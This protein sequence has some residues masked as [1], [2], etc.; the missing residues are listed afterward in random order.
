MYVHVVLA[1]GKFIIEKIQQKKTT[2]TLR[3]FP[4]YFLKNKAFF[5]IFSLFRLFFKKMHYTLFFQYEGTNCG[6]LWGEL[7]RS[8]VTITNSCDRGGTIATEL[9]ITE[10][11]PVSI[12]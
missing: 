2:S 7:L 6:Y 8:L 11:I 10:Q 9:P 4:L 1:V 12:T 3:K 5:Y